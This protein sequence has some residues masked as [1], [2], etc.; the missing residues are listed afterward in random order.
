[1]QNNILSTNY[2]TFK[3]KNSQITIHNL[4]IMKQLQK[5]FFQ[6]FPLFPR[7]IAQK[8]VVCAKKRPRKSNTFLRS[9]YL[10][11]TL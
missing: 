4:Y 6:L 9:L 11:E 3:K 7:V 10:Y 5:C 1:L 8:R 2:E